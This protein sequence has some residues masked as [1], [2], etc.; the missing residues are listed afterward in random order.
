MNKETDQATILLTSA[1]GLA[2]IYISKYLKRTSDYRIIATDMSAI[3]PLKEWVD[4]FYVVPPTKHHEFIPTMKRI[5]AEEQVDIVIPI[6]SHDVD[7]FSQTETQNELSDVRMLVMDHEDHRTFHNKRTCYE[8]LNA[9][10]IRTPRVFQEPANNQF[11][12]I[13][14]PEIGSGSKN[15][16]KIDNIDDYH[17]WSSKIPNSVLI[18][19]LDGDE[20]TVDCLFNA[21]GKCIGAN[22]RKRVKANSGAVTIT[23]NDYSIEVDAIIEQLEMTGKIKGPVNFQFKIH[24]GDLCIFDFNTRFASG[25]LPLTVESGFDIPNMLIK[26]ILD[27]RVETW[28]PDSSKHELTMVRYYEEYFLI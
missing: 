28:Y 12:F 17:Y 20:Y 1:G 9:Q 26:L 15:T 7:I 14:K 19:Y 10:K 22:V 23:S 11:P 16:V 13:M 5:V 8:Y 24:D 3:N 6:S 27:E 25:G 18:E 21:H 4:A 2:G